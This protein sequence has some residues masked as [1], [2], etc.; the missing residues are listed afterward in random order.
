LTN[1]DEP[2]QVAGAVWHDGRTLIMLRDAVLPRRCVKCNQPVDE[3]TKARRVYWFSPW[4]YLLLLLSVLVFAI[5]ALAVRK[6]TI[7][8]AGLCPEHKRRRRTA[9][10]IGWGGALAGIV[11]MYVG[12]SSEFGFWGVLA[13]VLLIL[14]ACVAGIVLGRIVYATRI[15]A[16]HVHL[17]GCGAPFLA[18]LP[19][20]PG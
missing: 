2:G 15:D 6:K 17:R 1:S 13:G 10:T 14:G 20:Y 18:S 11:L 8:A 3:P 12:A 9:L 4:L 19:R 7:V 16:T 5:V